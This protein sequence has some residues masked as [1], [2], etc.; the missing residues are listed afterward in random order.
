ML[1]APDG[2]RYVRKHVSDLTPEEYQA[3]YRLNMGRNGE[4][5]DK[6][7]F[8]RKHRKQ[9]YVLMLWKDNTLISWVLRF[10]EGEHRWGV[11][12][13]TRTHYRRKGYGKWLLNE[14]KRGL[15]TVTIYPWDKRSAGFYRKIN[16]N[17]I[18]NK[19][20]SLHV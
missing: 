15:K 20:T 9:A 11:Y 19:G 5:Q 7:S 16:P 14:S 12:V 1:R 13:Y 18:Y 2:L 10:R 6:I 3:C 8:E 4:M 17:T